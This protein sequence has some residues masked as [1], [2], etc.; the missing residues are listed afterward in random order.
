MN[1]ASSGSKNAASDG[2]RPYGSRA[3]PDTCRQ[4]TLARE[5]VI[6]WPEACQGL[7]L[8]GAQR[9]PAGRPCPRGRCPAREARGGQV[10]RAPPELDRT[11]LADERRTV[12]VEH[13]ADAQHNAPEA[14]HVQR[15]V[16]SVHPIVL[17]GDAV[18]D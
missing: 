15:I 13:A 3:A 1:S 12:M 16:R 14:A 4:P 5:L 9:H 6:A 7:L 2:S 18:V 8:F 17:K 11:A 10:K